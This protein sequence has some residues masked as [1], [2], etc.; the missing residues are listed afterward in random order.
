MKNIKHIRIEPSEDYGVG[1]FEIIVV[2]KNGRK[3]CMNTTFGWLITIE[4]AKR[5]AAVYDCGIKITR[6]AVQV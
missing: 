3:S 1:A 5:W 6:K 2:F 4:K